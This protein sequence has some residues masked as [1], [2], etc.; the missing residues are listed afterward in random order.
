[1]LRIIRPFNLL[2]LFVVQFS[3]WY[4]LFRHDSINE[5]VFY[6]F[7][8]S[9][10]TLLIAAAGYIINDIFDFNIDLINKQNKTYVNIIISKNNAYIYYWILNITAFSLLIILNKL[11][12]YLIGSFTAVSLFFYAKNLK[13]TVLIGNL[14]VA[15]LT[16]FSIIQF[17]F[18]FDISN[19][20]SRITLILYSTFAFLTTLIREIIKDIEDK[21][22][23]SKSGVSTIASFFSV[24]TLKI[25]LNVLNLIIFSIL[26][27]SY[28]I[29]ENSLISSIYLST[30]LFFFPPYISYKLYY[31]VKKEDYSY[32]SL[33]LKIYMMI[34][35]VWLWL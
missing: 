33:M 4:N 10:M 30:F 9:G 19:E 29:L 7:I 35:V 21:D 12:F 32:I 11:Y 17:R 3:V 25:I 8:V 6:F 24:K 31:A 15:L 1:M 23:D 28:F 13:K 26:V 34:G 22:G 18:Y 16:A 20:N 27:I 5:D 14:L 2:I